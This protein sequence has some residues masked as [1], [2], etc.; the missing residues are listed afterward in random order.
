MSLRSFVALMRAPRFA[1]ITAFSLA[2]LPLIASTTISL[3]GG[4][5][6]VVLCLRTERELGYDHGTVRMFAARNYGRDAHRHATLAL[7]HNN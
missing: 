3:Y 2:G 1:S 6:T 7:E 5:G 4:T